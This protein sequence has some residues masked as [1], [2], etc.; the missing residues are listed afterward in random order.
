MAVE[1]SSRLSSMSELP[2]PAARNVP[3]R[4]VPALAGGRVTLGVVVSDAPALAC[5]NWIPGRDGMI[6]VNDLV[7][8]DDLGS[9]VSW[10]AK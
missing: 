8:A 7:A 6:K 9:M 5:R 1:R 2:A 10:T 4:A 3:W